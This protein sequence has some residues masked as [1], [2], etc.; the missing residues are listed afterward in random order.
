MMLDRGMCGVSTASAA[1]AAQDRDVTS[2]CVRKGKLLFRSAHI[3]DASHYLFLLENLDLR[4]F[5]NFELVGSGI[6]DKSKAFWT[7]GLGSMG[8]QV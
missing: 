5:K 4:N 8:P 7:K 2:F 3:M 1:T 6:V